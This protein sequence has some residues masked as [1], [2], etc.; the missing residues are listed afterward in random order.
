MDGGEEQLS[1]RPVK[2]AAHPISPDIVR[3]LST[4]RVKLNASC[5]GSTPRNRHAT[6]QAQSDSA[7]FA[8]H[9][10]SAACACA[11]LVEKIQK[12]LQRVNS[13]MDA[14]E[15][16]KGLWCWARTEGLHVLT[17][18][19][20]RLF[21]AARDDFLWRDVRKPNTGEGIGI[22][23]SAECAHFSPKKMAR[24][25]TSFQLLVF[26]LSRCFT[27]KWLART[28]SVA[29]PFCA[30]GSRR[31]APGRPRACASV[32]PGGMSQVDEEEMGS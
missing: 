17:D 11:P 5:E 13:R 19:G 32:R 12:H 2:R 4:P 30:R 1:R 20:F 18:D 29:A 16:G 21:F 3:R 26:L 28:L 7:R 15:F 9:P 10:P 14:C 6:D 22:S 8:D 24:L 31:C 25:L 23:V 27:S